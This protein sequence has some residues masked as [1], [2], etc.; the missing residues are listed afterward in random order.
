MRVRWLFKGVSEMKTIPVFSVTRAVVCSAFVMALIGSAFAMR[1]LQQE[2]GQ[3]AGAAGF[4]AGPRTPKQKPPTS[5]MTP[6]PKPPTVTPLTVNT[7]VDL[8]AAN[9]NA[10][11]NNVA[12]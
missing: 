6:A 1:L 4:D 7:T 9:P 12:G 2:R 10:C 11:Q 5:A 3:N 8:V